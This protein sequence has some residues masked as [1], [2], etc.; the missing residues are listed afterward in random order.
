MRVQLH[1]YSP[2]PLPSTAR[3]PE[4]IGQTE[5]SADDVGQII[6]T[7]V[8]LTAAPGTY[9]VN[10]SLPDYP[11]VS[12]VVSCENAVHRCKAC[13]TARSWAPVHTL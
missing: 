5:A 3:Q 11:D 12:V 6:I 1:V 13:A 8:R 10:V 9:L 4:L 2:P 7:D